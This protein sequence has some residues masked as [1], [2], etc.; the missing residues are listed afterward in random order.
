MG[1]LEDLKSSGVDANDKAQVVA[2]LRN[3]PISPDRREG[4]FN[5]WLT[6]KSLPR[7]LRDIMQVRGT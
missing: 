2:Y 6:A 4:L 3:L 5:L 7:D 1:I